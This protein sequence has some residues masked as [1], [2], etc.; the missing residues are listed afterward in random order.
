MIRLVLVCLLL[1]GAA[2]AQTPDTAGLADGQVR[3]RLVPAQETNLSADG[4]LTI[5]AI[6]VDLG[7]RFREGE[8]LVRFDCALRE[9]RLSAARGALAAARATLASRQRLRTQNVAG[10][11]E[12]ELALAEVQKSAGAVEEAFAAVE[13]CVLRAPFTGRVARRHVQP[14]E[15]VNSDRPILS[16]VGEGR[17]R[18]AIIM[19]SRWLRWVDPQATF[20][21][22]MDET[23]RT[24]AARLT[25]LSGRVDAASQ[26]IEALGEITDQAPELLPGMSGTAVFQP[27]RP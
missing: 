27:P 13:R 18:V 26:T 7:D 21:V 5:Q 16:L 12:V 15:T 20:R 24:Y 6:T 10:A 3:V 19:P 23:G 8:V 9:A 14:F 11:Y 2:L 17:L 1:A 25:A 22:E 4:L